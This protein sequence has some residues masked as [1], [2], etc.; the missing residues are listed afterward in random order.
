MK[1]KSPP[2]LFPVSP[3][4]LVEAVMRDWRRLLLP[5]VGIWAAVSF[6]AF[7]G[8]HLIR[9][10]YE[11]T[12]I[13]EVSS[14]DTKTP[15]PADLSEKARNVAFDPKELEELAKSADTGETLINAA[16]ARVRE[17][18]NVEAREPGSFV[19]SFRS[20]TPVA[21]QKGCDGISRAIISRFDPTAAVGGTDARART[22]E[23]ATHAL[24]AFIVAHPG[25]VGEAT[26]LEPRP[27]L[28]DSAHTDALFA[29]DRTLVVLRWEKRR[30]DAELAAATNPTAVAPTPSS[31]FGPNP[32][33]DPPPSADPEAIK[34]RLAELR[35]A[36][37]ERQKAV[38][39]DSTAP[40]PS[41]AS[42]SPEDAA[43]RAQWTRLVQAMT[44][45][46]HAQQTDAPSPLTAR[47]I[48]PPSLPTRPLHP[49]RLIL[50]LLGS[51]FGLGSGFAWIVAR[52]RHTEE[53]PKP[54]LGAATH[55][56]A[57]PRGPT[58]VE[59]RLASDPSTSSAVFT[60]SP[61][62]AVAVP[63]SNSPHL[64]TQRG[65]ID[66]AAVLAQTGVAPATLALEP[67]PTVGITRTEKVEANGGA[68]KSAPPA[69]D[70]ARP[71]TAK[72]DPPAASPPRPRSDPPKRS[73][74]PPR[75]SLDERRPT[76][77]SRPGGVFDVTVTSPGGLVRPPSV[78]PRPAS[79]T[80]TVAGTAPPPRAEQRSSPPDDTRPSQIPLRPRPTI[81]PPPVGDTAVRATSRPAPRSLRPGVVEHPPDTQRIGSPRESVRPASPSNAPR[82]DT[83]YSIVN[84]AA[85]KTSRPPPPA[86]RLTPPAERKEDG[87]RAASRSTQ[88]LVTPPGIVRPTTTE[89]LG[90]SPGAARRVIEAPPAPEPS[91]GTKT[92]WEPPQVTNP[93][94]A[95]VRHWSTAPQGSDDVV[96]P[97]SLPPSWR[98]PDDVAPKD[99]PDELKQIRDQLVSIRGNRCFVLGITSEEQSNGGKTKLAVK[100][101]ELLAESARVLLMEANF[102]WPGVQRALAI[103]MPR[104]AG[105][106]QQIHARIRDRN[107][108]P[109][110]VAECS[111]SLHVLAEGIMRSP[112]ILFS[113]EFAMAVAELRTRYDF[114]VAD[115]PTVGTGGDLKPLN[116]LTDGIVVVVHPKGDLPAAL[117]TA[118]KWFTQKEF[119]AAVF[120]DA[121]R[122]H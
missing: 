70:V 53:I 61:N 6:L 80:T 40:A 46:E 120:A 51:M 20:N 86:E 108:G 14:R 25:I 66:V 11:S 13:V 77:S 88:P 72:S 106:S 31:D 34:R 43:L 18:I 49:T 100:L 114:I 116:V 79:M 38:V 85:S 47:V 37:T 118:A 99:A 98:P 21:A 8:V 113:Q 103:D 1:K 28:L 63:P 29:K 101:A 5:A 44:D 75:P 7:A 97:R 115:G 58:P 104:A 119:A 50:G 4:Q 67:R 32:Y 24:D 91:P 95:M 9:T 30:L 55:S 16:I 10:V 64:S 60:T 23:A 112:G 39:R 122:N 26:K 78:A 2:A 102:D 35:I 48:A 96:A 107:R 68:W 41:A 17:S 111:P 45:A 105:F 15:L 59:P 117:D 110:T 65:V 69:A 73:P 82:F 42:Q 71:A 92:G 83:T 87:F 22:L 89:P 121:D 76:A 27:A 36:I 19:I 84:R 74:L 3:E 57:P 54:V 90:A 94:T 93:E 52:M 109:W 81:S 56:S 62:L 33:N 12:G